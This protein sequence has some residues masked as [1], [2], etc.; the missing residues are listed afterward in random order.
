MCLACGRELLLDADVQLLHPDLEPDAAAGAQRLRL[1]DFLEAEQ[2]AE[3]AARLGLAAGR[4]GQLDVI[5]AVEHGR[6]G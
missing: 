4:R 2:P 6:E 1:L 3:E 5:D